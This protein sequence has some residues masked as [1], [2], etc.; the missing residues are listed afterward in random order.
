[1]KFYTGLPVVSPHQLAGHHITTMFAGVVKT[2]R[3]DLQSSTT[4]HCGRITGI[5]YWYNC[6]LTVAIVECKHAMS[7]FKYWTSQ[8]FEYDYEYRPHISLCAGNWVKSKQ[9]LIGVMFEVD[10]EYLRLT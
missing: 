6:N 9:H 3:L 5:E 7:R 8:G 1:M 4:L 2:D 10:A